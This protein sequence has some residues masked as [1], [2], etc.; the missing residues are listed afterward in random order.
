M[1]VEGGNGQ[2]ST[3]QWG[4]LAL[5]L[6]VAAAL[7]LV[8]CDASPPGVHIDE[9]SNIFNANCLLMTGHDEH[10][11][12]TPIFH[13]RAFGD[14][15]SALFLYVLQIPQLLA[16]MSI[17]ASR[18]ASAVCGVAA[19][20]LIYF[21][22][23]RLF[24]RP[25]GL[26]A[27]LMLALTP[28]HIQ[29]SR[30]AHEASIAPFL[31]LGA[32]AMLVGLRKQAPV[33][34]FALA[35]LITGVACYGYGAVR[36][37]L[38][39]FLLLAVVFNARVWAPSLRERLLRLRAAVL[40]GALLLVFTPLVVKHFTDPAINTRLLA[41]RA[42]ETTDG[43]LVRSWKIA[44]RYPMAYSPA[45]LF[46][47]GA[48]DPSQMPPRGFG[49]LHWYEAPLLLAGVIV[50]ASKWRDLSSRLV[51]AGLL[52]Y[53]LSDLLLDGRGA[54]V[55]RLMPGLAFLTLAGAVGAAWVWERVTTRRARRAARRSL[56]V[57]A[58]LVVAVS[59]TLFTVRFFGSF[60]DQ[61]DRWSVFNMDL[62]AAAAW[63]KP[64]IADAD[65]VIISESDRAFSYAPMMVYTGYTPR[66]WFDNIRERAT[67]MAISPAAY[68]CV[69]YDKI[70]FLIDPAN[71]EPLT[72]QLFVPGR[73]ILMIVR[74]GELGVA[75]KATPALIVRD[76]SGAAV[77]ECYDLIA[78]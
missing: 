68:G 1:A 70:H 27:A 65:A 17:C 53:P 37:F 21:I 78:K 50:L 3:Y 62:R 76:P 47:R 28:W 5:I 23:A 46:V 36:I 29:H 19:V 75:Q 14:N 57:G 59:S 48:R 41:G 13:T 15:R 18:A 42:W 32:V 9:A 51:A 45:F 34:R 39:A 72:K 26:I 4:A 69:R 74:P 67:L 40:I 63:L 73:R 12:P 66:Q 60:N 56:A 58:L 55:L 30:W 38:P 6:I 43:A 54:N 11:K 2:F 35:G 10:G 77:L 25:V 49:T 33:W 8:N 44:R 24:S 64:R 22:G 71:I 31:T 7:R 20:G 61:P 52:A 16:G